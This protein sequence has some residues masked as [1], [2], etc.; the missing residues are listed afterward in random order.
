MA[1][2]VGSSPESSRRFKGKVV[3]SEWLGPARRAR[4]SVEGYHGQF[5]V[6]IPAEGSMPVDVEIEI[7]LSDAA[8]WSVIGS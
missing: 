5:E 7:S 6:T 8:A 3:G 4:V 2:V 1:G